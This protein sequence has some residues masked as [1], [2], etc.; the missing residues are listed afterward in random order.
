MTQAGQRAGG[1]I[2]ALLSREVLGAVTAIAMVTV[3]VVLC[4]GAMH[5]S[6][7]WSGM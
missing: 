7:V 1:Y 3:I 2:G 4:V 6:G 5:A